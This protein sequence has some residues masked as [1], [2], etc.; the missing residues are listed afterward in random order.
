MS[1][2]EY[3]NTTEEM[4]YFGSDYN[5]FLNSECSKEMTVNN[6]DVIQYKRSK[7]ILRIV[8]SKHD[9]EKMKPSQE[10]VLKL[11]AVVFKWLNNL[12]SKH[13][14][15]IFIITGNYPYN[16]VYI[17]DLISG[18]TYLCKDRE[19]FKKFS[20]FNLS[21]TDLVDTS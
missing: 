9:K 18:I 19:R 13:K 15:E 17:R 20:E 8:E 3:R 16:N 11:L 7:K 14:F 5:K 4:N 6:I 10:E 2:K 21:I 1:N 12:P